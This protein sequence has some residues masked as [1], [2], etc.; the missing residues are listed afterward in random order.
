MGDLVKARAY[1]QSVP[2]TYERWAYYSAN[3]TRENNPVHVAVRSVSLYLGMHPAFQGLNDAR[4]PQPAASRRSLKGNQ[5]FPPLKP[6]MYSGWTG[7]GA[8]QT[9]EFATHIRF[10]SGLEARYIRIEAD[11]PNSAMLAFVNARRAVGG[12]PQVNLNGSALLAE[13]R[14]QRA[15]DFY[16]TGQRLGDLRRYAEAGMDLFPTGKFPV[17]PDPYGTLHCFIVPLSEKSGNPNY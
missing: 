7:T 5:I 14:A 10:A 13:F 8:A 2:D 17:S 1:A 4:V 12:K 3:S 16:L 6:S 11:G 15:R 9:I